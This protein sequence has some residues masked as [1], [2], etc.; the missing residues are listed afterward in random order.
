MWRICSS[1]VGPYKVVLAV[2]FWA[3]NEFRI[4]Q[5]RESYP[6]RLTWIIYSGYSSPFTLET[7]GVDKGKLT[8][9]LGLLWG[10]F[11]TT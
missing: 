8:G 9:C 2:P 1:W 10:A 3:R 7:L 5:K 6:D 11:G 4:D